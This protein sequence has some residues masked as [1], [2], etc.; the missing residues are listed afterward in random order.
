L[1][2]SDVQLHLI[3]F[4]ARVVALKTKDRNG[5]FTDIA[6]GYSSLDDYLHKKNT[7]FGAI[8]GRY[9]N[10]IARG[11]LKL[12]GKLYQTPL[13][14][15]GVNTLHGGTEG[16][17]R[18][19][20]T[21]KEIPHGV[22]FTLVSL[23]GDQGF[24]GKVTA[25]VQY[26]LHGNEVRIEYSATT[27]KT[28]VV[29]L[30]NHTYFNLSGE[31][32]GSIVGEKLRMD[33]DKFTPVDAWLIPKG[34]MKPVE[35]TP[36]D[37]R[38]GVEIQELVK[39]HDEQL[40][41]CHG[42]DHNWVLRGQIGKLAFAAKLYDPASGRVLLIKT[43]EPGLQF[44]SGQYFDGTLVG[45]SGRPYEKYSGLALETQ[46]FPDSPNHRN[47]PNTELKP[48]QRYHSV[49]TWTFTTE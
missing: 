21:A 24:P 1:S 43:T 31:G 35:G 2:S 36:F 9:A 32:G 14:N 28:T 22:E 10:R 41:I 19:N 5:H 17:D 29:N 11:H 42:F 4:G 23:D 16:F 25:H 7:Y 27:G 49:T 33:A 18:R 39:Q 48:G 30:T 37:F 13:N 34:A 8:V 40:T 45:K 46:H 47:F 38:K 3:T 15:L 26:T 6:L 44:N 20:W 12:E